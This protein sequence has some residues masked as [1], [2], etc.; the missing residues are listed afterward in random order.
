MVAAVVI[1]VIV[2]MIFV[3]PVSDFVERH[4]TFKI[5]ALS[6]LLLIGFA[7]VGEGFALHVPKGY[8]YFAMGFS[9]FVEILNIRIRKRPVKPVQLRTRPVE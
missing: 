6:F 4:P 9:A 3:G 8:L 5:L 2:M 1:A 7:L